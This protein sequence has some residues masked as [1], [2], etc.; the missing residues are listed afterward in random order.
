[1]A[2]KRSWI[3]KL[4][5]ELANEISKQYRISEIIL[6]GSYA[7][8]KPNDTSDIDIAVISKSFQQLTDIER[9]MYL[10]DCVRKLKITIPVGIDIIGFTP[11]ELNKANYFDLAGEIK[12]KGEVVYKKAA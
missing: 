11:E 4:I 12:E 9:I 10:T 3:K 7:W 2:L 8:G 6:F 1:M 5:Q